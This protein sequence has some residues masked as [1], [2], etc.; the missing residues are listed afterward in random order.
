MMQQ[1]GF[2]APQSSELDKFKAR[3]EYKEYRRKYIR[4]DLTPDE[5]DDKALDIYV[6]LL[7]LFEDTRYELRR[8]PLIEFFF[9]V[10]PYA[11]LKHIAVFLYYLYI[12]LVY[13]FFFIFFPLVFIYLGLEITYEFYKVLEF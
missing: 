4:S 11:F 8:I 5:L 3:V 2:K 7:E 6:F 1:A 12:G 10:F 9:I 13:V